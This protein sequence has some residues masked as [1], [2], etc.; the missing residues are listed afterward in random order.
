MSLKQYQLRVANI[1]IIAICLM[2]FP[3]IAKRQADSDNVQ[4]IG[5]L[6]PMTGDASSYGQKG[7][8]AIEI[9]VDDCNTLPEA[10]RKVSAI[11]EDSKANAKDGIS[12]AQKLISV[13]KVPAVVG[14]AVSAVTLP[15]ASIAE[16]NQVVLLSP[17]SSAPAITNAGKFIYRIWPSDLTEG[18]AAAEFAV[19]KRFKRAA[20]LLLNNDYGNGIAD[21]FTQY[22]TGDDRKVVLRTA[23]QDTTTDWRTI[24][25]PLI[26]AGADVIYIAGYYKDTAAILRTASEFGIKAQFIG[27]T[28]I[29]DE[30]LIKLAGAAAE[31]IVYPLATS[32]DAASADKTTKAFVDA[33]QKRFSYEPGWMESHAYDAFM[34]V[35]HGVNSAK[36][37]GKVTGE[38]IR[39]YLDHVGS[40]H[41]VT[42]DIRFDENGDV[43]RKVVF[44]T[45]KD[46][47][48]VWLA[49]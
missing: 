43:I 34:L 3:S 16:A 48:F 45:V 2:P 46:G 33:F 18:K 39:D 24:V 49:K 42:G 21:I 31:G 29:E 1:V 30:N 26:A 13:D 19:S 11:F 44:K 17:C 7:R 37:A 15:V 40:Y 27:A 4:K 35:C 10:N 32:F 23:Y 41:G 9:A 20:L 38:K 6:F 12:A 22:F 36:R 25:T 5:V 8:R 47:H 28:A 14:D